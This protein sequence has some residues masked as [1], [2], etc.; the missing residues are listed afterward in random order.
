MQIKWVRNNKEAAEKIA[1]NG[2]NFALGMEMLFVSATTIGVILIYS[3]YICKYDSFSCV[4]WSLYTIE[5]LNK[6]AVL[7][8]FA[9]ILINYGRLMEKGHQNRRKNSVNNNVVNITSNE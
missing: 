6:G 4:Y 3:R 8:D 5:N 1:L 9:E 2:R 7:R